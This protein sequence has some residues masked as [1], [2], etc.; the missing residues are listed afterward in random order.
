[1]AKAFPAKMANEGC[2]RLE[3][4]AAASRRLGNPARLAKSFEFRI[5]GVESAELE[6]QKMLLRNTRR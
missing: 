2:G 5:Y 4:D 1:V 3:K 6:C